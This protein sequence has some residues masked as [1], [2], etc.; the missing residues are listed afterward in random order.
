M[1]AVYIVKWNH[2]YIEVETRIVGEYDFIKGPVDKNMKLSNESTMETT[3]LVTF[4][5]KEKV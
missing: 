2:F 4:L 1:I 5:I 3:Q